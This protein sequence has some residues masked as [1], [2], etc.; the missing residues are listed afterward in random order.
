M[1]VV[2]S[3]LPKVDLTLQSL[4]APSG[5]ELK[6]V[7]SGLSIALDTESTT[8]SSTPGSTV[9]SPFG[10]REPTI[11][12]PGELNGS[13]ASHSD[14]AQL[15]QHVFKPWA[16]DLAGVLERLQQV[17]R[18]GHKL[19]LEKDVDKEQEADLKAEALQALYLIE[20]ALLK[21][22][23]H[24]GLAGVF[25]LLMGRRV[26]WLELTA[27]AFDSWKVP[28]RR[29]S[30]SKDLSTTMRSSFVTSPL[31]FAS[32]CTSPVS[33]PRNSRAPS[34]VP[35]KVGRTA[36]LRGSVKDLVVSKFCPGRGREERQRRVAELD[37]LH[38]VLCEDAVARVESLIYEAD[39]LDDAASH[40]ETALP[41]MP[42][43]LC[44]P[45]RIVRLSMCRRALERTK[46]G[47][48]PDW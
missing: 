17:T 8:C 20:D 45:V 39:S 32:P 41:K 37:E 27:K 28:E 3:R 30:G 7:T 14:F 40:L 12:I 48:G 11:E 33:S 24:S 5:S 46:S 23:S 42:V 1:A 36:S 29:R 16:Q 10:S 31:A 6:G 43:T 19:D 15:L 38:K 4:A 9:V 26:V 25:E 47:E 22:P 21:L 2:A 18:H 44:S 13:Q 34:P 35:A